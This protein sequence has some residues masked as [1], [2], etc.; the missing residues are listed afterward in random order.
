MSRGRL[1]NEIF[2]VAS[3][4]AEGI[5]DLA[6]SLRTSRAQSLASAQLG[7]DRNRRQALLADPPEW[8]V[9]ALGPPPLSGPDRRRWAERAEELASYRDAQGVVDERRTLGPKPPEPARRREWELARWSL[10]DQERSRD[11]ERGLAR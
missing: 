2:V 6:D 8:A 11:L 3:D 9:A 1:S 5:E 4:V 10:V 7:V